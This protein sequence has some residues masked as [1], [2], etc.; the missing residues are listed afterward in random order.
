MGMFLNQDYSAGFRLPTNDIAQDEEKLN[1]FINEGKYPIFA[2]HHGRVPKRAIVAI[3]VDQ[4]DFI[5]NFFCSIYAV[6]KS[7]NADV[8]YSGYGIKNI[9][10]E[11]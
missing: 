10:M 1:R 4:A 7:K 2:T 3:P 11:K 9:N 5:F 8:V 6:A